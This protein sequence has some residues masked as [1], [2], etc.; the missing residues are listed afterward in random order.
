MWTIA[1]YA[2]D[3]AKRHLIEVAKPAPEIVPGLK[4]MPGILEAHADKLTLSFLT[5]KKSTDPHA[6]FLGIAIS[7][8][9]KIPVYGGQVEKLTSKVGKW[10]GLPYS[11]WNVTK[12]K[13]R[14]CVMLNLF[15]GLQRTDL[16]AIE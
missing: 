4:S 3:L 12:S 5:Q 2:Q 14:G 10:L 16:E 11:R 9:V 8:P 6:G 7:C 13:I 15:F 1:G